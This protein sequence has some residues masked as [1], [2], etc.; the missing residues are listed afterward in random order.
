MKRNDSVA[1][2]MASLAIAQSA[3]GIGML[4]SGRTSQPDYYRQL[5]Q[6][7]W[8]PPPWIFAP[9][10]GILYTMMGLAAWLLWRRR[11]RPGAR[12]ALG[13]YAAQLA[14]NSAWS[15]IFFGLRRPRAA[16]YDL[17]A[18]WGTLAATTVATLR[19]SWLGGLLLMPYLGWT[20]FAAALNK[21]I[22]DL[23]PQEDDG[24]VARL[25]QPDLAAKHPVHAE[26]I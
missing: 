3:G 20:T 8:S 11:D 7:A 25:L 13:L 16:F 6:P 24:S 10:W 26:S 23:N 9:V 17:M 15:G 19:V 12:T 14:L 18:L 1:S 22:A 5:R 4:L 21:R 2:L